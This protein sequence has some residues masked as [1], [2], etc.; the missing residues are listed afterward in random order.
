MHFLNTI[1]S[2]DHTLDTDCKTGNRMGQ[3]LAYVWNGALN[4][5]AAIAFNVKEWAE[6]VAWYNLEQNSCSAPPFKACG[7][8]TQMVWDSSVKVLYHA[9]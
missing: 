2:F 5:D 3:N 4:N 1:H 8:Y 9:Q 6:E 7:H